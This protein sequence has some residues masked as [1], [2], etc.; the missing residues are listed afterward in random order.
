MS[1]MHIKLCFLMAEARGI[2]DHLRKA[3]TPNYN[4]EIRTCCI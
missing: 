3:L 4:L 2:G 1:K